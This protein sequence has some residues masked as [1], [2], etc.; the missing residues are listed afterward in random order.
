MNLKQYTSKLNFLK[1]LMEISKHE[2][3]SLNG[4]RAFAIFLVFLEHAV[5]FFQSWLNSLPKYL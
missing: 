1:S 5:S 2:I 3:L 4:L